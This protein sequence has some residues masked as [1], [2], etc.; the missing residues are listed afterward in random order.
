[1]VGLTEGSP[2]SGTVVHSMQAWID[3]NTFRGLEVELTDKTV[4]LLGTKVGQSTEKFFIAPGEKV[5]T[6]M[7][8]KLC[9]RSL[10]WI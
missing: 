1:M 8:I 5:N 9:W 6:C 7:G 10:W 3:D 4:T 2:Q